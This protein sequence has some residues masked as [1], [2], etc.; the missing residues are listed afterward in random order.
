MRADV[1]I[2]GG[3]ITGTAIAREL[4][5]YDLDVVLVE[6]EADIAFGGSTKANTG[7]IHAGYD[8]I[9]GTLKARLCPQGNALW[10]E[11]ASELDVPFRRIGSLVVALKEEEVRAL[12]ELKERGERNGVPGLEIID[13]RERLLEMEPS[14]NRG[15]IAALYAPTAGI[16]SPYEMAIALAENAERN[17]VRALLGTRVTDIVVKDGEVKGVLTDEG[18][19]GAGCV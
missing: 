2:I 5:R 9:P 10:P 16:A 8:D 13:D 14:L 3:G 1:V 4:S 19:I 11:L 15:A 17:G 7:I 6:K 18:P 12:K